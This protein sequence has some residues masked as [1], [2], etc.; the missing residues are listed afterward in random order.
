MLSAA[1][2]WQVCLVLSFT[3]DTQADRTARYGMEWNRMGDGFGV[4]WER[5]NGAESEQ[6][7]RSSI[8]VV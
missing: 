8:C 6:A 7:A 1:F 3:Q 4:S 5:Q 2:L